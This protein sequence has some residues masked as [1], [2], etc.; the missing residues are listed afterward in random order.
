MFKV[1]I[2]KVLRFIES[3]L[4]AAAFTY[5]AVEVNNF[6]YQDISSV[7]SALGFGY[8][9]IAAYYFVKIFLRDEEE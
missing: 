6:G 7:M 4:L 1:N 3:F 2:E 9:F 8:E 5:G